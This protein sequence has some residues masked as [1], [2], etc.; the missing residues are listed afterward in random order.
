[1]Q[2]LVQTIGAVLAGLLVAF[3]ITVQFEKLGTYWYPF[4]NTNPNSEAYL[5][6]ME[7]APMRLHLLNIVG[8]GVSVLLGAYVGGRLSPAKQQQR[9]AFITGFTYLLPLVI[10]LIV[11]PRPIW[12]IVSILLIVVLFTVF[13]AVILQKLSHNSYKM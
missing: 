3:L 10:V 2:Q 5:S 8:F 1:M 6:Y 7:T 9:G 13:A 12:A 11:I 4:P